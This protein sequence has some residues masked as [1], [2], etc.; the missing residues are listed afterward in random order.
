MI[1]TRFPM[2]FFGTCSLSLTIFNRGTSRTTNQS[3]SASKFA[4]YRFSYFDSQLIPKNKAVCGLHPP[5]TVILKRDA[6]NDNNTNW[7]RG[8]F[9]A[10]FIR[11]GVSHTRHHGRTSSHELYMQSR[12]VT[13]GRFA[14]ATRRI[15]TTVRDLPGHPSPRA[16]RGT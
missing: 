7:L 12:G 8:F 15:R 4:R 11:L 1:Q 2:I 3:K 14:A 10:Y 16:L 6:A 5:A 9:L 13:K